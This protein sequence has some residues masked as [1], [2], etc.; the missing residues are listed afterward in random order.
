MPDEPMHEFLGPD[1]VDQIAAQIRA[2]GGS[3]AD[4]ITSRV[5]MTEQ[6]NAEGDPADEPRGD[7]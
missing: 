7:E 1:P 2:D 3:L 5:E 4:W 6:T